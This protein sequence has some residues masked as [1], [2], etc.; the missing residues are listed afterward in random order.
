L[1]KT[2]TLHG[3]GLDFSIEEE[4]FLL[5]LRI[6]FS[7]CLNTHYVAK[8]KDYYDRDMLASQILIWFKKC[9]EY[10]G[11]TYKVPSLVPI[12]KWMM[13]NATKV[14]AF[15]AIIDLFPDHSRWTFFNKK[16]IVNGDT[17]PRK[18]LA[19]PLTGYVDTIP[20]SGNFRNAHNISAKRTA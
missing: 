12:N 13:W 9:F 3:V 20:V 10:A 15:H 1:D 11:G 19:D 14:M 2:V 6:D 18:V 5:A 4:V 7:V 17:L 16:H 8:L